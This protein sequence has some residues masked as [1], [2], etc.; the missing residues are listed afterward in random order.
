MQRY[1]RILLTVESE[2][3]VTYTG[4][5]LSP[6]FNIKDKT[7]FEYQ[8]DLADHVNC[9]EATCKNDF[10]FETARRIQKSIKDHVGKDYKSNMFKGSIKM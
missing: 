7:D 2:I 6:Q 10:V 5:K 8:H 1:T 4:R 3:Q 9:P